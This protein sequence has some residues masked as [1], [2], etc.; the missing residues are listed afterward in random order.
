M[1][2]NPSIELA[3]TG[4]RKAINE[5]AG[6]TTAV[7]ARRC[8]AAVS[9]ILDSSGERN[10][11]QANVVRAAKTAKNEIGTDWPEE[12]YRALLYK[13]ADSTDEHSSVSKTNTQ[14]RRR[15]ASTGQ[16]ATDARRQRRRSVPTRL[17]YS[18]VTFVFVFLVVVTIGFEIA[19]VPLSLILPSFSSSDLNMQENRDICYHGEPWHN[20]SAHVL[21]S[22][23]SFVA[24]KVAAQFGHDLVT[25]E[26]VMTSGRH[27]WEVKLKSDAVAGTMIGI[28]RPKLNPVGFYADLRTKAGWFI[29]TGDGARYGNGVWASSDKAGAF[30]RGDRCGVLLDLDAGSLRFFK[31]GEAHGAGYPHGAVNGP[32]VPGMQLGYESAGEL[33][34]TCTQ[35][36]HV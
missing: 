27:Y 1:L 29:G 6:A 19:G 34:T 8:I 24:K 22:D 4:T 23:H 35:I 10:A 18:L 30:S 2:S 5:L 32:V 12:D 15:K 28:V 16:E 9:E 31:N 7:E 17:A 20:H 33:L 13:F 14:L 26:R 25:S 36:P 11:Q 21:L 3:A